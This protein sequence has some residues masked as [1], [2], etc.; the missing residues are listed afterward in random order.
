[1]KISAPSLN[2]IFASVSFVC[3]HVW[4]ILANF[5]GHIG[6][7]TIV[8]FSVAQAMGLLIPILAGLHFANFQ[9]LNSLISG[10][11]TTST[12]N[13]TNTNTTTT[14]VPVIVP[15]VMGSNTPSVGD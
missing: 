9:S 1:M 2:T 5:V 11:S 3:V 13:S 10:T 14:S 15:P 12:S 7:H 4:F 6:S 8:P